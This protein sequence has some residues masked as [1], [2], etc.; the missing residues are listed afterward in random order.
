MIRTVRSTGRVG[1]GAALVAVTAAGVWNYGVPEFPRYRPDASSQDNE[2]RADNGD[3]TSSAR[4]V[5]DAA[6]DI[7]APSWR[8]SFGTSDW[9]HVSAAG[10]TTQGDL[11]FAGSAVNTEVRG[12]NNAL[13]LSTDRRGVIKAHR[14]LG[15]SGDAEALDLVAADAGE[16]VLAI[17]DGVDIHVIRT[18]IEGEESWRTTFVNV[19]ADADGRLAR[20]ANGTALA[21]SK[22]AAPGAFVA[23]LND[24]GV[25][26]WR[27]DLP[28]KASGAPVF[29]ASSEDGGATL[30]VETDAG[31]EILRYSPAGDVIWRSES[32]AD[33]AGAPAALGAVAGGAVLASFVD[34]VVVLERFSDQGEAVWSTIAPFA[35]SPP[36]SLQARPGLDRF[37]IVAAPSADLDNPAG[38][39]LFDFNGDGSLV[40]DLW[41]GAMGDDRAHV[42]D[43]TPEGE[44]LIA[45]ASRRAETNDPDM[46]MVRIAPRD[47]LPL[48]LASHGAPSS[49]LTTVF[50]PESG[51]RQ[52]SGPEDG[53]GD[54]IETGTSEGVVVDCE[55]QC[56]TETYNVPYPVSRRFV[57]EVGL[58]PSAF[59]EEAAGETDFIC[60]V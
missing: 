27:D 18:T 12:Q 56:I 39:A 9:E 20:L 49:V 45:G 30:A 33:I 52:S 24:A 50:D 34:K 46:M 16:V 35:L 40:G 6:P 15:N 17:R 54:L 25:E 36:L 53:Q 51:D 22:S 44:T 13:L 5:I 4:A 14:L 42:V 26:T 10:V 29:I 8:Q 23:H 21:V 19:G 43:F 31:S 47:G 7:N 59:A 11:V 3:I 48:G 1:M 37:S 60:A 28:R 55:F 38:F 32:A 57:L 2:N 41:L 58:D